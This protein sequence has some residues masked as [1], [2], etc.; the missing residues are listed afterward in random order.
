[1][2]R[3]LEESS[4]LLKRCIF[5]DINRVGDYDNAIYNRMC[6]EMMID[7]CFGL[8]DKV[9]VETQEGYEKQAEDIVPRLESTLDDIWNEIF[10]LITEDDW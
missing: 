1:M 9:I 6:R 5:E 2:S 3:D 7:E 10:D 8:S 4:P